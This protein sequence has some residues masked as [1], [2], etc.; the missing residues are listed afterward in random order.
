M[1]K[2]DIPATANT[3]KAPRNAVLIA[4]FMAVFMATIYI[5]RQGAAVEDLVFRGNLVVLIIVSV[6]T[7]WFSYKGRVQPSMLA[8]IAAF[9]F[10]FIHN[11]YN[12]AG[13]GLTNGL[14]AAVV[15]ASVAIPTLSGKWL[16]WSLITG[17]IAAALVVFIDLFGPVG[18]PVYVYT[19]FDYILISVLV[20]VFLF[21]IVRGFKNYTLRGKLALSLIGV[22]VVTLV[23][24]GSFFLANTNISDTLQ[25]QATEA[26][27]SDV[28]VKIANID[29][30]LSN[31]NADTLFLSQSAA[32]INYLN[33]V[34]ADANSAAV[35]TVRASLEAEFLAFAQNR[36][37]YDQIRFLDAAGQEIVRVD[38][39]LDGVSLAVATTD[40]QNKGDRY[41]FQNSIDLRLGEVYISPLDLNVEGGQIQIPHKPMLR[42]ATPVQFNGQT[43]GVIVANVLAENF[44]APLS[45]SKTDTFLVDADGYYLYH[46]DQSKRWGRDLETGI[47][48]F[49]DLP[50]L[51]PNLTSGKVGSFNTTDQLFAFSPVTLPGEALPRWYLANFGSLAEA[52][53]GETSV[54]QTG[55]VAMAVALTVAMVVAVFVSGFISIPM[56]ELTRTVEQFSTGDLQVRSAVR[57]TDEIGVLAAAFNSMAARL[58][59]TLG[60][61][62]VRSRDLALTVDVGRDISQVRDLTNMLA[63]AVELIRDRFGLYYAQ[64]YLADPAGR[65][66]LL[67]VGTGQAGQT[68]VERGHRLPIAPGSIN[69][70]AAANREAVIVAD[71]GQSAAH[72]ANP[73]LPH[74][75]SEMAVPLIADDRLL[76]ILNM[77]S[78]TPG[79]L[80]DE[81]L[82]VF[83]SLASQLAIA[84]KN[85]ELLTEMERARAAV[86][87]GVRQ[88]TAA[89][90]QNFFNAVERD[91]RLGTAYDIGADAPL[92]ELPAPAPEPHHLT[93]P[94]AVA[95]TAVG[96]I[97][98]EDHEERA[99]TED[100][101]EIVQAVA[102]KVARQIENL[103]LVSA[104]E[105]ARS[106]AEQS[107]RRLTREGWETYLTA[108][109]L[110]GD[111]FVYDR[112]R[113]RPL[114][115]ET[116]NEDNNEDEETAV[117]QP[118]AVRGEAIGELA[119]TGLDKLDERAVALI[120]AVA[121]KVSER[122]ETLR[123]AQQTDLA[124]A[125][126]EKQAHR[127]A[128]LNE[129]GS[130]LS[131]ANTTNE[132]FAAVVREL[133]TIISFDQINLTMVDADKQDMAVFALDGESGAIPTDTTLPIIGTV[134]GAAFT[135]KQMINLADIDQSDYLETAQL[136]KMGLR[137]TLIVP[138][139]TAGTALG[140]LSLG[141]MRA[142]AFNEQDENMMRQVV[143]LLASTIESQ[144]L[145]AEAQ[146]QAEKEHFINV[147]SEKIQRATTVESA[148]ETAVQELGQALQA[149]HMQISLTPETNG[150]EAPAK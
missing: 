22:T 98:L 27:L 10:L 101:M 122:V 74:T 62:Q 5:L 144:R 41:Y 71:T 150:E 45:S 46:P 20:G 87:E 149:Q 15:T 97:R 9:L 60:G 28:E 24:V 36:L 78:D 142:A 29:T 48:A 139:V 121:E 31:S 106:E 19:P 135:Q 18:R 82:P 93:T 61:L 114:T 57:S 72:K 11:Q 95:G 63:D 120:R 64:V 143:P 102:E 100:E 115:N 75:R 47:T 2:M 86:E 111:G 126:T 1:N 107:T 112:N 40:L 105:Q 44:L 39:S 136:L 51:A 84:I 104:A 124:L 118:L 69:G 6:A 35:A 25:S 65:T 90:W 14:I 89:G 7:A 129:L 54:V 67:Q 128:R 4:A 50:Q 8:L 33:V 55:M 99:W 127:L 110:T 147:I 145:F 92:A 70:V 3:D 34:N 146:S 23:V 12:R 113:V 133:E 32:L 73:L 108:T 30:H 137:S 134:V 68:L 131:T 96:A 88:T 16:N 130:V 77:Q 94:I 13:N 42:Y 49:Q 17:G 56:I 53:A 21:F 141:S 38:T 125:Q 37:I 43:Q 148:L 52:Q 58:Q 83:E 59:K 123:L 138:L 66:L 117:S 91:E 26:Q 116:N 79:G 140:T 81:R 76:G 119:L 85:V 109:D 103:R 132:V 80:N